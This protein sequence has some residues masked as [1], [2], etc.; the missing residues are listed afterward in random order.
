VVDAA[1]WL[2]LLLVAQGVTGVSNIV[3][4]WPLANALAHTAGAALL[5]VTMVVMLCRT[6]AARR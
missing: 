3:F 4:E 5:V 6:A 1:R 2:A